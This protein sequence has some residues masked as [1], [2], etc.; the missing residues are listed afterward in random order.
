M[1]I[2]L[3]RLSG[4]HPEGVPWAWAINGVTSVLGSGL[5]ILIAI[6]WGFTATTL[7]ALACYVFALAHAIRG[8]WPEP[9]RRRALG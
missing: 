1:P 4:L 5:A 3:R 6:I 8:R 9:Q 2:A 7:V